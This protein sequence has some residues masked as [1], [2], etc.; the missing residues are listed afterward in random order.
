[1]DVNAIFFLAKAKAEI[2]GWKIDEACCFVLLLGSCEHACSFQSVCANCAR[3]EHETE[4]DA[5]GNCQAK[6]KRFDADYLKNAADLG[7]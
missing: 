6:Q 4:D 3:H 7:R 2:F 5:P 1:M